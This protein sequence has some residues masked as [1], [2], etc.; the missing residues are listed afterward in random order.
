MPERTYEIT[1]DGQPFTVRV[2]NLSARPL[3]VW[4]NG[5][6]YQVEVTSN[7]TPETA[8]APHIR[9][10]ETA[11]VP[12]QPLIQAILQDQSTVVAPMPGHILNIA[13]RPGE[14]VKKGQTLC[15]LEAMKM[16]N[17]IRAP[18]TGEVTAVHVENG[19]A[20]SHGQPLFTLQP[21]TP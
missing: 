6:A 20:V 19:Q 14:G 10:S 16:K 21:V 8:V 15:A 3:T 5:R 7:P 4:V 13:A 12:S 11:V 17:A 9:L 18:I 1:V 2:G